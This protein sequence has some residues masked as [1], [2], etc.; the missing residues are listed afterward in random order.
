MGLI[1]QVIKGRWLQAATPACAWDCALPLRSCIP[2]FARR[3]TLFGELRRTAGP[4]WPSREQGTYEAQ[5]S[6]PGVR[7]QLP[8]AWAPRVFLRHSNC[9]SAGAPSAAR[10]WRRWCNSPP[11]NHHRPGQLAAHIAL[12]ITWGGLVGDRGQGPPAI[13]R[14]RVLGSPSALR[15]KKPTQDRGGTGRAGARGARTRFLFC[16]SPLICT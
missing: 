14:A 15:T 6:R 7:E 3:S 13:A 4:S 12:G 1:N 11:P 2:S 16:E 5:P 9:R 8:R 10:E